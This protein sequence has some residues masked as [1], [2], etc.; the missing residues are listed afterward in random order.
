MIDQSEV[1]SHT[2]LKKVSYSQRYLQVPTAKYKQIFLEKVLHLGLRFDMHEIVE[3]KRFSII[4][5]Y[6][7]GMYFI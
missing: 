4:F 6:N 5:I 3:Y 2:L 1:F 7:L